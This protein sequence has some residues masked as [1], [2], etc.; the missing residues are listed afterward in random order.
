MHRYPDAHDCTGTTN[1][2]SDVPVAGS[3]VEATKVL[4]PA[5][6]F[7]ETS[8]IKKSITASPKALASVSKPKLPKGPAKLAKFKAV[9]LKIGPK[10]LDISVALDCRVRLFVSNEAGAEGGPP[11]LLRFRKVS[12]FVK[13]N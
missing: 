6:N 11:I 10:A 13:H 4:P 1:S 9:E 7:P 12:S 5:E 8:K 3:Q 2:T